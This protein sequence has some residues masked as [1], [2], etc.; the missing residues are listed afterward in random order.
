MIAEH[1]PAIEVS[2][3]AARCPGDVDRLVVRIAQG[4]AFTEDGDGADSGLIAQ[5]AIV[6]PGRVLRA[7]QGEEEDGAERNPRWVEPETSARHR[8]YHTQP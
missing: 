3:L 8:R 4:I 2:P 7:A 1:D 6:A 5:E